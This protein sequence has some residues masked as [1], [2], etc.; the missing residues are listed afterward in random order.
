MAGSMLE[1]GKE[2]FGAPVA[3]QP[4]SLGHKP[5]VGGGAKEHWIAKQVSSEG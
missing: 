3:A 4:L 5:V 2:L 1:V